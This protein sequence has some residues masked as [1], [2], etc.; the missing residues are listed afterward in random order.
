MPGWPA[1]RA[2][3]LESLEG[4]GSGGERAKVPRRAGVRGYG[5]AVATWLRRDRLA[6]V[7]AVVAPFVVATMLVPVRGRIE[8]THVALLLVVVVVAV[9]AF[10]NRPAGYLAALSAGAWFDFYFTEPYQRFAIGDGSDVETFVLLMAVGIAVTELAVRGRRQEALANREAGYLAGI[11]AA[12]EI[13]AT[14]GS[15]QDLIKQVSGQLVD[16]LHLESARYQPGVAGL[17][18][19]ARLRRDGQ[20]VWKGSVW[21]VDRNGLPADIDIELLVENAGRLHGRYLLSA[22]PKTSAPVSERRV[23]VT[24]ADQVGAALG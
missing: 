16:T 5:R 15:S 10:G 23:A 7:L 1:L 3:C 21:D 11:Q 18:G 19:P 20:I 6:V 8:G 9:A 2:H 24:L 4:P 13:G 12:A 14:G 17:G 22:V